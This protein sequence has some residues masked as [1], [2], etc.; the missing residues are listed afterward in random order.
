MKKSRKRMKLEYKK[1]I[2][3]FRER[4]KRKMLN[5]QTKRKITLHR[6]G[7]FSKPSILETPNKYE[8]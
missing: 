2:L 3:E 8:Y 4:M 1:K 5:P 6:S 7:Y